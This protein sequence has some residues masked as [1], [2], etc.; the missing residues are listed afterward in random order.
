MRRKDLGRALAIEAKIPGAIAQDQ[1]DR[2]VHD[3]L[4]KLKAGKPVNLVGVGK[5]LPARDRDE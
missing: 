5:L 4:R 2:V 3:I 1:V